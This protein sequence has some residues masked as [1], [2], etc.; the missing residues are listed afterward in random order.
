LLGIYRS[1]FLVPSA[2]AQ[3]LSNSEDSSEIEGF[4]SDD[5][6]DN[7]KVGEAAGD[8]ARNDGGER[9]SPSGDTQADHP[10]GTRS[11]V[12]K[13]RSSAQSTSNR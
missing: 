9:S 5:E 2:H 13:R 10:K 6:T 1:S 3:P 4:S 8:G 12:Q 7:A 11:V